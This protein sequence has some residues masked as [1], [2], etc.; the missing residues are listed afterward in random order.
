MICSNFLN[1]W[2]KDSFNMYNNL[3]FILRAKEKGVMRQ[4][5]KFNDE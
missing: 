3:G 5:G 1:S 4:G 2:D